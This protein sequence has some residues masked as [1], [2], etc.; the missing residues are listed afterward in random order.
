MKKIKIILLPLILLIIAIP[1]FIYYT[2][3]NGK[4]H[5]ELTLTDVATS[6]YSI[7]TANELCNEIAK[8]DGVKVGIYSGNNDRE[9]ILP[10]ASDNCNNTAFYN[11]NLSS[12]REGDYYEPW[13][14]F[15]RGTKGTAFYKDDIKV[16]DENT[17]SGNDAYFEIS[18]Y[19]LEYSSTGTLKRMN[20]IRPSEKIFMDFD[21]SNRDLKSNDFKDIRMSFDYVVSPSNYDISLRNSIAYYVYSDSQKY[22]PYKLFTQDNNEYYHYT[23][24]SGNIIYYIKTNLISENLVEGLPEN[25]NIKKIRIVPYEFY[26]IHAGSFKIYNFSINGYNDSFSLNKEYINV[27]NALN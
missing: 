2:N 15:G 22:G 19:K 12:L 10:S 9:Y 14:W 13:V 6:I 20:T 23:N 24:S 8:N 18:N 21:I 7:N 3:N 11:N 26:T 5:D 16:K 25:I 27:S 4:Y 17:A 1:L